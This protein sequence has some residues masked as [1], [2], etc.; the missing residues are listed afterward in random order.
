MIRQWL[1]VNAV[2]GAVSEELILSQNPSQGQWS[3]IAEIDVSEII[4]F[5]LTGIVHVFLF[6]FSLLFAAQ[7]L[8]FCPLVR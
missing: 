4:I 8:L 7:M 5:I 2:L 3:I 6:K 1:S